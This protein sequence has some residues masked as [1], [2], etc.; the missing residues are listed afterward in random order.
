[1]NYPVSLYCKKYFLTEDSLANEQ[2]KRLTKDEFIVFSKNAVYFS[3]IISQHYLAGWRL[4]VLRRI[5]NKL[6]Q[7]N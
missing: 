1:M 2:N 3:L 7:Y 5:S 6:A 4:F